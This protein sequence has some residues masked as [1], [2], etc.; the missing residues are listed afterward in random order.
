[1]ITDSMLNIF[2]AACS[3]KTIEQVLQFSVFF[4]R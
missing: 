2:I 1:M 3:Q 4:G